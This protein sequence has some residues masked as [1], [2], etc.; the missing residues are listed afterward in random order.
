MPFA[1]NTP[2]GQVRLMDLPFTAFEVI[3]AETGLD[4][5]DVV[6]APARTA[7]AARVVYRVACE[8][9]GSTPVDNLSPAMLV[10]EDSPIFELV[11]DDQPVSHDPNTGLPN[12]E[13]AQPTSG[14]SGAPGD[15]DGHPT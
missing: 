6:L 1:V 4:W 7:K 9:N 3:E 13:G 10:R 14:S 12:S 5:S 2:G 11:S 15:S 8:S